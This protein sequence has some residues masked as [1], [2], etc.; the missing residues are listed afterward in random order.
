MLFASN[1]IKT[2]TGWSPEKFAQNF[3]EILLDESEWKRGVSSLAI[4][5]EAQIK[6]QLKTRFGPNLEVNASLG[7]IPTG[8]FRNHTIAVVYNS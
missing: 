8:I 6:L 5:S 7:M 3:S 1:Q 2:L 4:R